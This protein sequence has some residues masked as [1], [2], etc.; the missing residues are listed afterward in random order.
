MHV[1]VQKRAVTFLTALLGR[2]LVYVCRKTSVL[3]ESRRAVESPHVRTPGIDFL[4]NSTLLALQQYG[5]ATNYPSLIGSIHINCRA[6]TQRYVLPRC[7]LGVTIEVGW[8]QA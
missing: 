4:L 5:T 3:S 2:C 8:R 1:R 6:A 7:S